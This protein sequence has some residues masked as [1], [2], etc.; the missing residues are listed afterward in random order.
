MV[1]LVIMCLNKHFAEHGQLPFRVLG[2]LFLET[3][4]PVKFPETVEE[5]IDKKIDIPES[6]QYLF[7]QT[8]AKHTNE[9]FV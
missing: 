8:K 4:H 5:I 6:V 2:H 7:D 1:L 3:A 9:S